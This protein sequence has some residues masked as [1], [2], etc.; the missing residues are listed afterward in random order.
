MKNCWRNNLAIVP[1]SIRTAVRNNGGGHW[2]H[3]MFWT[4]LGPGGGAAV[5]A[6]WRRISSSTFGSFDAFK[7]KFAN[8][9]DDAV[10]FRLGLADA[11]GRQAGD[12][13]DAESGFPAMEG[14]PV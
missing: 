1:E 12:F 5:R 9:G 7:E 8:A 3:S 2:N 11:R 14:K 13:I 6:L 10:R 4:I